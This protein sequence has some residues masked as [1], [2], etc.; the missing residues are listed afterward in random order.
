MNSPTAHVSKHIPLISH[1][2]GTRAAE[3][4]QNE[5]HRFQGRK[6]TG[7]TGPQVH[8]MDTADIVFDGL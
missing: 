7:S 5:T 1:H 3:S 2:Q 4:T 6:S 8:S